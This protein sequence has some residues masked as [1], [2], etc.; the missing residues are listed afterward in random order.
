L[1]ALTQKEL[2]DIESA[3]RTALEVKEMAVRAGR[4]D[5]VQDADK[6]LQDLER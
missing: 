6:F 3:K 4:V 5:I 1:V 2:G